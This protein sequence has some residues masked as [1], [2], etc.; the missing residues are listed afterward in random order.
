MKIVGP[1]ILPLT[2]ACVTIGF[3]STGCVTTSG[4]TQ[5]P[6]ISESV[7][8]YNANES[9]NE[10]VSRNASESTSDSLRF[11]NTQHHDSEEAPKF[12]EGYIKAGGSR[13]HYVSGGSGKLVV[14]YHGFPSYWY[15]WKHQLKALAKDY[16]VIAFDGLGTNLSDKP[17]EVSAYT[18]SNLS[19]QL[20]E[21]IEKLNGQEPYMLVGHDWGGA[22]AWAYAQTNPPGLE[23]LV[24]LSAPPYNLFLELLRSDADQRKASQYVEYLKSAEGE[25]RLKAN[26]AL[27][28]WKAGGYEKFVDRGLI[29]TAEGE[30]FK[31]AMARPGSVTGGI[32]WYRANLPLPHTISTDDF[33][34]SQSAST[35]VDS[36]LIWGET[37]ETFV[38]AFLQQLPSYTEQL[39]IEILPGVGHTPQLEAPEKVNKLIRSFIESL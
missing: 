1:A 17:T 6:V 16:R 39:Q 35:S 37:D 32:N 9:A 29:S 38:P 27:S 4:T 19:A 7:A 23:K 14:F 36:M 34:P 33:W 12:T 15:I 22:M 10:S 25:T 20:R 5:N 24:V 21:A 2:L 28:F 18:V 8:N 30:L 3:V 11:L 31:T 26:N 13:L